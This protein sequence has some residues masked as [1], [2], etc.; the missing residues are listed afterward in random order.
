MDWA[1]N[2]GAASTRKDI[3]VD[4]TFAEVDINKP[5]L[6]FI[7]NRGN[8]ASREGLLPLMET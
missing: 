5:I 7:G 6:D 8:I 1:R 3:G 4:Y 2:C